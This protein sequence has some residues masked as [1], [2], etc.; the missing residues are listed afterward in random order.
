M[1]GNGNLLLLNRVWYII[2]II[3]ALYIIIYTI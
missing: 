1:V 3:L 2:V